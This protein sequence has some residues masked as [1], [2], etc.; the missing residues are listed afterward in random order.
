VGV[1]V[2]VWGFSGVSGGWGGEVLRGR[3]VVGGGGG[4]E[5]FT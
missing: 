2:S 3:V 5:R 1:K 4:G